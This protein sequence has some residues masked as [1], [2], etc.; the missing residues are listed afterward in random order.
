MKSI[1]KF[2]VPIDDD[3]EL[4]MPK[5]ARILSFQSQRDHPCIWALVDMDTQEKEIRKFRMAG[6]GHPIEDDSNYSF[7][8][9]A[10]M[11]GGNLVWHLFEKRT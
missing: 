10:Q 2:P 1:W 4:E 5:G 8:G 3:I 11:M 7:V 6:T 9:T